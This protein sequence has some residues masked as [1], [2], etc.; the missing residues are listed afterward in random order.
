MKGSYTLLTG[1]TGM[2]GRYLLRDL[3]LAGI[4]VAVLVRG[5]SRQSPSDRIET[6]LSHWEHESGRLFPRPITLNGSLN[7][8][9]LDLNKDQ[10]NW[11]RRNCGSV[12]NSAGSLKFQPG[13]T[14]NE[15]WQTNVDGTRHLLEL[16]QDLGIREFH[17]V[18][19]AYVAGLRD[20]LV[21]ENDL[22]I[23][24]RWGN[25]YE[26]SKVTAEKQIR[27][28]NFLDTAT[29]YRPSIIVGDSVTGYT[30]SFHGFYLPL[31]AGQFLGPKLPA[32]E[33]N[34]IDLLN[35]FGLKG[36]DCKNLVPVDWVS[37]SIVR[38]FVQSSL[39]NLTYHLTSPEPVPVQEMQDVY[40][41][42][43]RP[44][45]GSKPLPSTSGSIEK[46]KSSF[47][48]HMDM[49][50]TY[51]RNDPSFDRTNTDSA[52]PDLPCPVLNRN[53]LLKLAQYAIDS[54][55]YP[56]NGRMV[57]ASDRARK[58]FESISDK[59]NFKGIKEEHKSIGFVVTGH[60]GTAW[61]FELSGNQITRSEPGLPGKPSLI[62]YLS[63]PTLQRLITGQFSS[64]D[65]VRS[66]KILVIGGTMYK[67]DVLVRLLEGFVL[68]PDPESDPGIYVRY[69]DS[70][71][72]SL[73]SGKIDVSDSP[74]LEKVRLIPSDRKLIAECTL[75]PRT[76]LFLKDHRMNGKPTLPGA[77][78]AEILAEAAGIC[79]PGRTF[80]GLSDFTM[81]KRYDFNSDAPESSYVSV[82]L[83]DKDRKC[84]LYVSKN[85]TAY[86]SKLVVA[87]T[88]VHFADTP[89]VPEVFNIGEPANSW[90][91]FEYP[92]GK[93]HILYHGP[94]MRT[95]RDLSIQHDGG[96]ARLV[97]PPPLQ[98]TSGRSGQKWF[99]PSALL[100]GCLLTCL[101]YSY[102]MLENR[103]E[104]PHKIGKLLFYRQPCEEEICMM[105]FFVRGYDS[106]STHFD[107]YL[108]GEDGLIIL[109]GEDIK[110]FNL[111]V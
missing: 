77:V 19:T 85:Q 86:N 87:K 72:L 54:K 5:L 34:T 28:S 13:D 65:A 91:P 4:P 64:S 98:L 89:P 29:I 40:Y 103:L 108:V 55:F 33:G 101:A 20:G 80:I 45:M 94:S 96:Y 59:I 60:G 61:Q 100:D 51:W 81:T 50:R 2:V 35:L 47:F 11:L 79:S 48:E 83:Q 68:Q 39:H 1:A 6:I 53:Q 37:A 63:W 82:D 17:H 36:S 90:Q 75:D 23:G 67:T 49:Y 105:R 52:L 15:P 22:D 21:R 10:T 74:L 106:Q 57:Q 24:Q 16:C 97:G 9:G 3:L 56:S 42:V 84:E 58:W 32:S 31:R 44:L 27:E 104:I 71:Y 46:L 41:T 69:D 25:V 30:S 26:E 66:G 107:F 62:F 18:S 102:V 73:I 76:D 8:E 14:D 78:S 95:I 12:I 99:I 38:I 92:Q 111:K 70:K 109:T 7:K 43:L 110:T 88:T 93:W